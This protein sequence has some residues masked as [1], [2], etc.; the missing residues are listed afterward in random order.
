L[1]LW[2]EYRIAGRHARRKRVYGAE[3]LNLP[4]ETGAGLGVG[5]PAGSVPF[6]TAALTAVWNLFERSWQLEKA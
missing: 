4:V 2:A 1:K 5:V 6:D 3:L